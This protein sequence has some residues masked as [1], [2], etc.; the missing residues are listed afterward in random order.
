MKTVANYL[1]IITV[2]VISITGCKS[3]AEKNEKAQSELNAAEADLNDAQNKANEAEQNLLESTAWIEFER[4]ANLTILTNEAQIAELRVKM[5]KSGRT[6]DTLYAK[7]IDRLEEENRNM[8]LRIEAYKKSQSGWENFKLEFD[9]DMDS[10]G[11]ALK[12]LTVDNKK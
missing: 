10:L 9:R 7:N 6:F 1:I 4:N 12:D 5:S 3:A 2:L 8:R 11:R